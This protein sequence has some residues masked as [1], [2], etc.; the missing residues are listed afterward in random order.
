MQS[1]EADTYMFV[2]IIHAS[3]TESQTLMIVNSDTNVVLLDIN[4]A[5]MLIRISTLCGSEK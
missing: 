5:G 2:H 3:L 1:E 4:V